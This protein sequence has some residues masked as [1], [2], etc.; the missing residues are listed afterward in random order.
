VYIYT[1]KPLLQLMKSEIIMVRWAKREF[2][3]LRK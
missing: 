2:I 3:K 1:S